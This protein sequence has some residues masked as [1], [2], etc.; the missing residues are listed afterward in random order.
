MKEHKL[1]WAAIAVLFIVAVVGGFFVYFGYQKLQEVNIKADRATL[2][3]ARAIIADK[4]RN[5]N[6]LPLPFIKLKYAKA[7]KKEMATIAAKK[8]FGDNLQV[9]YFKRS[10]Q[11]FL[12][13][14]SD[15]KFYLLQNNNGNLETERLDA[16]HLY[17][18]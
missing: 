5:N 12:L 8:I 18:E 2:A 1:I 14:K 7:K 17:V 10:T 13:V 6:F 16:S 3:A 15:N 4:E 9:I 11:Y